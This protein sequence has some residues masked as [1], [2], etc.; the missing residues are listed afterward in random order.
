MYKPI[1]L[2]ILFLSFYLP[3]CQVS[4]TKEPSWIINEE[5]NPNAVAPENGLYGGTHVLLY[6]E[7]VHVDREEAYIKNVA[8]VIKVYWFT[9]GICSISHG[10]FYP[11]Y[12]SPV[13]LT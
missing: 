5:Y 3:Y 11:L 6:T 10:L 1:T 2:I 12:P 9:F 13:A 4:I 8:K 7:Q